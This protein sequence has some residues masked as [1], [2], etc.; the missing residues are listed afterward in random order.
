MT[1]SVGN[2]NLVAMENFRVK[3]FYNGNIHLCLYIIVGFDRIGFK[4]RKIILPSFIDFTE[5]YKI[6]SKKKKEKSIFERFSGKIATMF[7]HKL[8]N[9]EISDVYKYDL[10]F[11]SFYYSILS[12][13]LPCRRYQC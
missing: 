3:V 10:N 2:G 9:I 5:A 11:T 12:P 4:F 13:L 6:N 7:N 1:I 8:L